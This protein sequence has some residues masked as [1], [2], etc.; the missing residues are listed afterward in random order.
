MTQ[1]ERFEEMLARRSELTA[2]EEAELSGHV[3]SCSVCSITAR[4]YDRQ[5]QLLHSLTSVEPPA[6]LRSGVLDRISTPRAAPFWKR[7]SLWLLAAPLAA[8]LIVAIALSANLRGSTGNRSNVAG[9]S[10]PPAP[11]L[12]PKPATGGGAPQIRHAPSPALGMKHHRARASSTAGSSPPAAGYSGQTAFLAP[13]RVPYAGSGSAATAASG[14]SA[15][16]TADRAAQLPSAPAHAGTSKQSGSTLSRVPKTNQPSAPASPP[17]PVPLATQPSANQ[18][19]ATPIPIP[20]GV[21]RLAPAH[22]SPSPALGTPVPVPT[23]VAPAPS[24]PAPISPPPLPIPGPIGTPVT[25]TPG[26]I[27]YGPALSTPV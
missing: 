13:T 2:T 3:D 18:P 20:T 12:T 9:G 24:P 11:R 25:A 26:S 15:A 4:E 5:H 8:A 23:P 14:S 17:S 7:R 16:Q 19:S 21:S 22:P 27:I 1:H 6:A 10:T